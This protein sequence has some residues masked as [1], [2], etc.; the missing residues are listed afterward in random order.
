MEEIKLK[1]CPFCVNKAELIEQKHREY[2]GTF[3]VRCKGY[4]I[5][6]RDFKDADRAVEHWN[7]R[8]EE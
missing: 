6:Q 2:S 4:C 7:R 3:Y 5:K 8:V 1:P